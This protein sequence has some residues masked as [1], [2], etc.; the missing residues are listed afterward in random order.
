MMRQESSRFCHAFLPFFLL[1]RTRSDATRPSSKKS[2]TARCSF[3]RGH[4]SNVSIYFEHGTDCGRT[5]SKELMARSLQLD[6]FCCKATT[7][8]VA[9]EDVT[10]QQLHDIREALQEHGQRCETLKQRMREALAKQVL[11]CQRMVRVEHAC[12]M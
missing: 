11:C 2:A 10:R 8:V 9:A 4:Q 3:T 7:N 12:R 1:P 5:C 6:C